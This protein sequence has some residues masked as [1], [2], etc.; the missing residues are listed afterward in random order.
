[1]PLV[2]VTL[3]VAFAVLLRSLVALNS[4]SGEGKPP[5]HGDY[6]A[7]RHWMEIT[8]H[9]P[10]EQWYVNSSANDLL[11]WGLDYPPLTAYHSWLCGAIQHRIN[12]SWVELFESRGHE[13]YDQKVFM[14]RSV[15]AADVL[16][17]IP[18]VLFYFLKFAG[19]SAFSSD[20]K[21][22]FAFLTLVSPGLTLID[23]GHFQY[24]C[25]SLGLTVWAIV[26]LC[27]GHDLLG[28][29]AFVLALNYKQMELYHAVAFFCYLLG[30]CL[31][32]YKS[33]GFMAGLCKL[34]KLA[35]VVLATFF[36]CWYPFLMNGE[37]WLH[38]TQVL[39]RLFPFGRGLYE[40]KVANVW[41]SLSIVIKLKQIFQVPNLIKICLLSTL[42]ALI[43]SSLDL[44][45]RPTITKF[46]YALVNS[47][48]VFF[49][50]S[51]QVH[52]KSI[53]LVA[54]PVCLLMPRHTLI[55]IWFLLVS[56]FSMTPLLI[57]DGLSLAILPCMILFYLL[58]DILLDHLHLVEIITMQ[59]STRE[60][61]LSSKKGRTVKA[62]I[63]N[64]TIHCVSLYD[65][66][67]LAILF[68]LSSTGM[69]SLILISLSLPPPA[70]LPD[71]Y[72]VLVSLYSCAHF[73]AFL[74]FFHWA[75]LTDGEGL[76]NKS[77]EM[78]SRATKS[79]HA[80]NSRN[81][82]RKVKSQ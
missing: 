7:Q 59:P 10:V 40:D 53:L 49:L 14:R 65:D 18:A 73:L 38:T 77:G 71:L 58:A 75:Q 41:C 31:Q 30:K 36:I 67:R 24:N 57:K 63:Q 69:A 27:S 25:I 3:V 19:Y 33:S 17:Y 81:T 72:P 4:Y 60:V 2:H 42:V 76:D 9:L 6:E 16:I 56:T 43:P 1:M 12:S 50:F 68:L 70:R 44:L 20:S 80:S 61:P 29:A 39:Q 46:K 22:V 48:L 35:L 78:N 34:L 54:L 23:H 26:G 52:E 37:P 32:K 15:L 82:K 13:S 11:Y 74:V 5:M 51:F 79:D 47:S 21:L 45:L 8:Y 64:A 62:V 28:S 66:R 55:S